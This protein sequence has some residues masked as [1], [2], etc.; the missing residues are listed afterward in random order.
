MKTQL[1]KRL[2]LLLAAAMLTTLAACGQGT[3][4]ETGGQTQPPE[5]TQQTGSTALYTPGTYT[6]QADGN[7]GPVTVEVVLDDSAIVSVAVTEHSETEGLSDPAIERIPAAITDGQTLA[8]DT[9]AGATN[10]SNAILAAVENCISQAGGD[11]Q[12]LKEKS[13]P[14]DKGPAQTIEKTADIVIIGGG[15]AGLSAANSA[16]QQGAEHVILLEKM[17]S[18]GGASAVAGGIAGGCSQLQESFSITNDSPELIYDDLMTGGEGKNDPDLLKLFSEN[19]GST[20]DWLISDMRVPITKQF[21]NFPEHTVQRS[22]EVDGGSMTMISTLGQRFEEQGGEILME[23]KA[24]EL[25]T[26]GSGAVIGVSAEDA[27]GNT[28]KVTAPVTVLATGGF[29][30]NPDML[31]DSLSIALFYGAASSTGEGIQMAEAIGAQTCFMDYAKMYPQGIEVSEGMGKVSSVHSALTTQTTGAIYVN[32]EGQRVVDENLDFVSIKKATVPQTDNVIYLVMDQAA[33]D[34]WCKSATES[35]SVSGLFTLEDQE[36]WFTAP[37][38][39]DPVFRRGDNLVAVGNAAGID[40][41]ALAATV[42]HWNEMV[43]AGTDADFGREELFPLADGP[44]YIIEQ[45][46]RFATTLGGVKVN[47]NL[48]VLDEN[49]QPI[50]G[51]YAAGECVGGVHGVE[52]MPTCMLSWAAT[53]GKLCGEFAAA[54]LD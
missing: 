31:S 10:T 3:P 51:F 47:E 34:V 54:A 45:K 18:L 21:S 35:H 11:V 43:T 26:D 20:L 22:F 40:G 15:A 9:V 19:M 1:K 2:G 39:T 17:A 25:I 27:Q 36:K 46:L 30:N 53:S 38:G 8:V 7:N 24:T 4:V 29:G 5:Q 37:D 14:E 32:K 28:V 41:E 6:A 12:A 44:Y 52:S 50:S 13:A 23:A 42:A 16:L 49:N 48:Q 33:Y